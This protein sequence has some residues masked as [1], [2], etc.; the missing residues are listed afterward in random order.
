MEVAELDDRAIWQRWMANEKMDDLVL[1]LCGRRRG[2]KAD[3]ARDRIY[4]VVVPRI[5]A[6]LD[7][8]DLVEQLLAS[9]DIPD[10]PR[11]ELLMKR[12]ARSETLPIGALEQSLRK[13]LIAARQEV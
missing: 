13:R 5:V 11:Y 2:T 12:L 3:A 7:A 9:D 1:V 10:D 4:A 8:S 6:E